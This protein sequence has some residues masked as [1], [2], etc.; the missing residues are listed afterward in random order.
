MSEKGSSKEV[1]EVIEWMFWVLE[2]HLRQGIA[3]INMDGTVK[4]RRDGGVARYRGQPSQGLDVHSK[5][6]LHNDEG[7]IT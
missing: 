4:D 1:V 7:I 2:K 6:A 3:Q 5:R